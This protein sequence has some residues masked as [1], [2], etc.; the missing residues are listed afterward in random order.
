MSKAA[1]IGCG[2]MGYALLCG[3][4]KTEKYGL[5][6]ITVSDKS[7]FCLERAAALGVNIAESPKAAAE[8]AEL[9]I[10]AVKPNALEGLANELAGSIGDNAVIASI[11]A[12]KTISTLEGYFGSKAKIIRIMPNTPALVGEGMSGVC[13]NANVS[14]E[15]LD[16]M[17]DIL[18]GFGKAKAVNESLMDAV[19]GISG[20]GPA[21][22]FMFIDGLM[23]AGVNNGMSENDAKVYAAQTVLGA[24]KMVLESD[25]SPEQLKINVCSP[26]GTTIEAVKVFEERGLYEIIEEAV[27]AC[28]Q[29]SKLMSKK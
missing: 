3:I 26:G 9:V 25:I 24:A 10:L 21:Y 2:N 29:K 5:N 27:G 11:L 7:E 8:G 23:K 16:N 12:G 4:I 17:L 13:A 1:I 19:T 22:A 6:E 20:S 15:D 14:A 18:C 28:V